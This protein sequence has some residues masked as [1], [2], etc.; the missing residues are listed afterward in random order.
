MEKFISRT[1]E[2]YENGEINARLKTKLQKH[3]RFAL[4]LQSR[5][6]YTLAIVPLALIVT[7]IVDELNIEYNKSLDHLFSLITF[8]EERFTPY[9]SNDISDLPI[10]LN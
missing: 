5:G 10:S 8:Q 6:Q 2:L 7:L 4:K 1:Y 9:F 3:A